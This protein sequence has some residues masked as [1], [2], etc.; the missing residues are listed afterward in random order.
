[1]RCRDCGR[2][3]DR[4][5]WKKGPPPSRCTRCQRVT[6]NA[7]VARRRTELRESGD[8]TARTGASLLPHEHEA[9]ARAVRDG[10]SRGVTYRQIAAELGIA[11]AVL[12]RWRARW[13]RST[14]EKL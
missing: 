3:I 9:R 5:K 13:R 7:L 6:R 8:R 14:G 1:M 12:E 4:P 10:R 11:V 2:S